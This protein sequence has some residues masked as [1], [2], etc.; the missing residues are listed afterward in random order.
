M[1]EVKRKMDNK[2]LKAILI[3]LLDG[4]SRDEKS[5][6]LE[7]AGFNKSE[8]IGV[9]GVSKEALKKREYRGKKKN[10]K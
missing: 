10:G 2:L 4:K 8:M 9:I 7:E 5:K 3:T 1:R 6:I